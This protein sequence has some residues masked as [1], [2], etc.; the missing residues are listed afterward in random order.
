MTKIVLVIEHVKTESN[1]IN[2]ITETQRSTVYRHMPWQSL[3]R[4][5]GK[6]HRNHRRSYSFAEIEGVNITKK[7][8]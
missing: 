7:I 2:L 8:V 4:L 3:S 5:M 6:L 1:S